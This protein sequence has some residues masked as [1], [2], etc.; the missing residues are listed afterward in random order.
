[1]EVIVVGPPRAH[2]PLPRRLR[3]RARAQHLLDGRVDEDAID[4]RIRRGDADQ[5][6]DARPPRGRRRVGLHI[7]DGQRPQVLAV[8]RRDTPGA[9][10]GG[11]DVADV[12]VQA[13]LVTAVAAGRGTTARLGQIA[14]HQQPELAAR[15]GGPQPAHERDQLGVAV[16]AVA[17]D[18]HHLVASAADGQRRPAL[19]A[20]AAARPD[21]L[22]RAGGG[23]APGPPHRRGAC[24]RQ[25]RAGGGR[26]R[27]Q[28][29][30]GRGRGRTRTR[31][32]ARTRPPVQR[33]GKHP[34][35]G[36]DHA[37]S[38]AL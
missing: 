35:S 1:M 22:R 18:A 27:N 36:G 38:I 19:Q 34:D 26:R 23:D 2:A 12:G 4:R 21:R 28:R 3:R 16:A 32:G 13:R 11:R 30:G 9:Q 5:L 29:R 24:P 37:A 10:A 31:V 33:Q 17:T 6:D 15:R 14:D 20:T 25:Q 8:V 7:D